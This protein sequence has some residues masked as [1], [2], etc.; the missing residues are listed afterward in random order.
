MKTSNKIEW[1]SFAI[2]MS[3]AFGVM[4]WYSTRTSPMHHEIHIEQATV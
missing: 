2:L 4:S 3:L 1:V